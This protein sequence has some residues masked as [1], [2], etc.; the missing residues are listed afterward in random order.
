AA[1]SPVADGARSRRWLT[2]AAAAAVVALIGVAVV[3]TRGGG[4][5]KS[6]V[7][8]SNGSTQS[9]SSNGS[10][11]SPTASTL[12][13][14]ALGPSGRGVRI[15]SITI[16]GGKYLVAYR[17]GGFTPK[18]DHSGDDPTSHHIHFFF[19]TVAQENAG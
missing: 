15:D 18:I 7:A 4:S 10:T 6:N 2:P 17:T 1:P 8:A 14:V 3:L 9:S 11:S 5:P 19:D 16:S 13:A 12:P